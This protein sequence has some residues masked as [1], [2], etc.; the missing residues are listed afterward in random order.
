MIR[1]LL[2]A[3][4]VAL[5]PI[6]AGCSGGPSL[7]PL[8]PVDTSSVDAFVKSV[9]ADVQAGCGIVIQASS[10]TDILAALGVPYVGLASTIVKQVCGA[11][12]KMGARRGVQSEPILIVRGQPIR[13]QGYRL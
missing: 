11:F 4:V 8:V 1:K 6:L 12:N 3:A 5:C 13:L 9:Q 7:P 2:T 10:I